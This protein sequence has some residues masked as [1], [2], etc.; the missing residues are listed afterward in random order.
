[1]AIGISGGNDQ[2]ASLEV[3]F[4]SAGEIGKDVLKTAKTRSEFTIQGERPSI[5][6]LEPEKFSAVFVEGLVTKGGISP[7]SIEGAKRSSLGLS[8]EA[9]LQVVEAKPTKSQLVEDTNSLSEI[10]SML[11]RCGEFV[12]NEIQNNSKTVLSVAREIAEKHSAGIVED[13][14]I[15]RWADENLVKAK[16]RIDKKISMIEEY[17][18]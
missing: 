17:N 16:E 1:M 10:S 2:G 6:Y 12:S 3:Q 13:G 18:R 15:G 4:A 7:E 11:G 5:P 8:I 9:A 14:A